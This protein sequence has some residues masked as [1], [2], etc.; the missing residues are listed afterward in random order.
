MV[1]VEQIIPDSMRVEFQE[2]LEVL[3]EGIDGAGLA[4]SYSL[5][6]ELAGQWLASVSPELRQGASVDLLQRIV[7][8]CQATAPNAMPDAART[9]SSRRR[10]PASLE[11]PLG[12]FVPSSSTFTLST[13]TSSRMRWLSAVQ[14]VRLPQ[15]VCEVVHTIGRTFVFS[16]VSGYLLQC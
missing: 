10:R 7:D 14:A 9:R 3:I 15:G 12:R 1:A 11:V 13:L 16:S 6:A 5:I 8:V 2:R 4:M